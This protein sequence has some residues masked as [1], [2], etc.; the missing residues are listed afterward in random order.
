MKQISWRTSKR[1]PLD[2]ILAR[3]HALI[4][5]WSAISHPTLAVI[6]TWPGRDHP[7]PKKASVRKVVKPPPPYPFPDEYL[8]SLLGRAYYA[9]LARPR[10][11]TEDY[12]WLEELRGRIMSE[13]TRIHKLDPT[14]RAM[15]PLDLVKL[16]KLASTYAE[17][18]IE[19]RHL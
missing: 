11:F 17:F 3:I 2:L 19:G 13:A 1:S 4:G 6:R 7:V 14:Q 5:S 18:L 9:C 15:G 12:L 16:C 8:H 10:E